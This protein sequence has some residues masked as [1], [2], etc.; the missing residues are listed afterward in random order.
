LSAIEQYQSFELSKD[1]NPVIVKGMMGIILEVREAGK[2]FEVE[3][4]RED[5]SN[6]EYQGKSSFT[7]SSDY[8]LQESPAV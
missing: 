1:L 8:I 2:T 6:Y 7:I 4:P 5:D 3:F